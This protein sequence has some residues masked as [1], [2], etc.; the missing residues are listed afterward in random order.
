MSTIDTD[1]EAIYVSFQI[2]TKIV[3]VIDKTIIPSRLQ[4]RTD[5]SPHEDVNDAQLSQAM[6]KIKFWFEHIVAKSLA[7]DIGNDD[8]LGIFFDEMGKNK[9]SNM[10]MLTPGDPSDEL[11]AALFQ[12]KMTALSAGTIDFALCEVKSDNQL[13]LSFTF[14][15][16]A[17][18]L[19]PPMLEW[20]GDRSY[21]DKP[22][23]QR[24][25]AS[26]L[27]IIPGMD[28]DLSKKPAWA[29]SLDTVGQHRETGVVVR[30]TFKPTVIPGGKPKE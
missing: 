3:R 8:A 11:L 6:N 7:F 20:I 19:L 27:D 13:G 4:I 15:G 28:A 26:T 30:P 29:Y 1:Q 16:D 21:F 10:I 24:N 25:D 17:S 2:E 14:V 5:V 18:S 22:W 9:T 12:A 23:W